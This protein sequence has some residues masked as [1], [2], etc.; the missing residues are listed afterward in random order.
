MW[1]ASRG[2]AHPLSLARGLCWGLWRNSAN[3]QSFAI[4]ADRLEVVCGW[5]SGKELGDAMVQ[6]GLLAVDPMGYRDLLA[7]GQLTVAERRAW[8]RSKT[9]TPQVAPPPPHTPAPI[10]KAETPLDLFG[11]VAIDKPA[12]KK[13]ALSKATLRGNEHRE[14]IDYFVKQWA[15]RY[16][17][18]YPFAPK[19]GAMMSSVLALCKTVANAKS[20]IDNYLKDGDKFYVGHT[21][22]KFLQDIPKFKGRGAGS[23]GSQRGELPY[24]HSTV[25]HTSDNLPPLASEPYD[26]DAAKRAR[27]AAEREGFRIASGEVQGERSARTPPEQAAG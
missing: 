19:D 10:P 20:S 22:A 23:G 15:V 17:T 14:V 12:P 21:I 1:L 3:C 4:Q 5:P 16:G 2:H 27:L 7:W 6:A 11:G 8:E 26:A 13:K 9:P 18:E 24:K 25:V